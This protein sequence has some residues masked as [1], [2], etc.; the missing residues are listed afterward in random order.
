MGG[1]APS[2]VRVWSLIHNKKT[3]DKTA[4]LKI[5]QL[6]FFKYMYLGMLNAVALKKTF[7]HRNSFSEIQV[8]KI[9]SPRMLL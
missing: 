1:E 8:S 4:I 2:Q 6:C 3:I 5:T 9:W 7:S